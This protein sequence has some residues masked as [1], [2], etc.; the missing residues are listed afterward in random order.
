MKITS[1]N[2][3]ELMSRMAVCFS[4]F[5]S[6]R[7]FGHL[8][9]DRREENNPYDCRSCYVTCCTINISL[10]SCLAAARQSR[11]HSLSV[12]AHLVCCCCAFNR[13]SFL[14]LQYHKVV[15]RRCT[16]ITINCAQAHMEY[17]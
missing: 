7:L 9:E 13:C 16:N 6:R 1:F 11:S 2:N 17:P 5:F 10:H 4:Q 12:C 3:F 14:K 8:N 15:Y